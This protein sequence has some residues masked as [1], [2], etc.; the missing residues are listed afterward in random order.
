MR[1]IARW[2]CRRRGHDYG[3]PLGLSEDEWV[4]VR[5]GHRAKRIRLID[6]AAKSA[7]E[8]P[9]PV[10]DMMNVKNELLEGIPII[11]LEGTE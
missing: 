4:C 8:R 6:L 1:L 3:Y 11:K 9:S 7:G 10:A 2:I 5:C